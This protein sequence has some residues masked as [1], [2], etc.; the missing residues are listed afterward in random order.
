MS[1]KES[2]YHAKGLIF[3]LLVMSV[4]EYKPSQSFL[5]GSEN[6]GLLKLTDSIRAGFLLLEALGDDLSLLTSI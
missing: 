4:D 3:G 2:K 5:Q 6:T 1:E